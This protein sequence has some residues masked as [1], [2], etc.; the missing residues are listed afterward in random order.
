ME[1]LWQLWLKEQEN[2]LIV[3]LFRVLAA[4]FKINSLGVNATHMRIKH[5][6]LDEEEVATK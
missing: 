2:H 3:V 5:E 6:Y 4:V 1:A